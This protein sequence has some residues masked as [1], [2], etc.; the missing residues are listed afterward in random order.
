MNMQEVIYKQKDGCVVD[1]NDVKVPL[2]FTGYKITKDFDKL[3]N[4]VEYES[5]KAI[6]NI[7]YRPTKTPIIFEVRYKGYN[8]TRYNNGNV[9]V[10]YCTDHNSRFYGEY[11]KFDINGNLQTVKYYQDSNDVTED[12]KSFIGFK[13]DNDALKFYKFKEDEVFNIYMLYG[14]KFKFY[15]EYKRDSSY[16]DE[17]TKFCLK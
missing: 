14:S 15:N 6:G 4:V 16:F 3:S 12:L 1:I 5:G 13:G 11:R 17:V 9:N 2:Y 10:V 8:E 7:H